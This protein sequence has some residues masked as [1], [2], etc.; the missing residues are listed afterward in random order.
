MSDTDPLDTIPEPGV[1][2]IEVH[3]VDGITIRHPSK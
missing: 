2:A 3:R 1:C